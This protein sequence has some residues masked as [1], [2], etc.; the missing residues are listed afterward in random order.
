M[1]KGEVSGLH[2]MQECPS[3]GAEPTHISPWPGLIQPGVL[4][5]VT[6]CGLKKLSLLMTQWPQ[7]RVSQ[8]L[9]GLILIFTWVCPQGPALNWSS[10]DFSAG[11]WDVILSLGNN[12]QEEDGSAYHQ[13][14]CGAE[15]GRSQESGHLRLSFG[16][17]V[18]IIS[19]RI[20]LILHE[21]QTYL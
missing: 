13:A 12:P 20:S 7:H 6:I 9:R 2:H 16:S 19:Q 18:V 17:V 10:G 3:N 1:V 8:F 4:C 15:S 11:L 5:A 14:F 21:L